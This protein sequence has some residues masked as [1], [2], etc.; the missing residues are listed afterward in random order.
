M[1]ESLNRLKAAVADRYTIERELGVGGMA[2]V[3]LARDLKHDRQ[4]A[5]KVLR[6]G[7][8]SELSGDRFS[9]EIKVAANLTHPHIL[10]LFDSGDAD[11]FLYYVMPLMEGESLRDRIAKSQQMAVDEVVQIVGEVADA[12][13]YAHRHGTVHRDIKP[14]N[15][16]MHEGHALV[17]DFGIA[18]A[19]TAAAETQEAITQT[20]ITVGTPAYMVDV[21]DAGI[22]TIG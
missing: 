6:S 4:V 7:L 18:K 8:S 13:D 17:A 9:R 14:E 16:M 15:I 19:V 5:L 21:A 1:S 3:Y 20:G 22:R 10:P 12:L 11:G 2:T